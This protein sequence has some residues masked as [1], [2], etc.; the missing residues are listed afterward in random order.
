MKKKAHKIALLNIEVDNFTMDEFLSHLQEGI[1]V[2]PNVDHLMKL[3]KDESF[4]EIYRRATHKVLDSRVIYYLLKLTNSPI[5]GVIPGSELLPAFYSFHRN[6]PN[7]RIFL[8]GGMNRTAEKAKAVINKKVNREIVTGAY[9][10]SYGFEQK[11]E[12]NSQIIEMIN[13][14]NANVLIVGVGAP[15]Q[16]KWLAKHLP[17]LNNIKIA[18]ALGASIDFEAGIRKRSPKWLQKLGMEWF[19]RFIIEP[20]RLW[21]RY[22]IDDLPFLFLFLRQKAGFYKNPFISINQANQNDT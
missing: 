18:M 19:Y 9:S 21:R 1:V 17:C 3:Q 14:S 10:P 15:K 22:F 11:P 8:L 5:K 20:R 2:T 16:E 4:Y 6:N 7:I 12:E 13:N